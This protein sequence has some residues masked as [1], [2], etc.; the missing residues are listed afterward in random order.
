[1]V[2]FSLSKILKSQ[3]TYC[4]YSE[5]LE[6]QKANFNITMNYMN[7]KPFSFFSFY[8]Y[9]NKDAIHTK[10]YEQSI[11]LRSKDDQLISTFSYTSYSNSTKYLSFRIIPLYDINYMTIKFDCS[12]NIFDLTSE[13]P[14][15]IYN[16]IAGQLYLFYIK[17]NE[18]KK[19]NIALNAN[20]TSNNN[21]FNSFYI[22]EYEQKND[23][24]ASYHNSQLL[25]NKNSIKQNEFSLS[26]SY[27]IYSYIT[28]YIAFSIKPFYNFSYIISKYNISCG[29]YELQNGTNKIENLKS[30]KDYY[31]FIYAKQF[32]TVNIKIFINNM[33]KKPFSYVG[34]KE[35]HKSYDKS[36]IYDSIYKTKSIS[37]F[38]KNNQL[39]TSFSTILN[40]SVSSDYLGVKINPYYDI[41]NMIVEY[42][43][44]DSLIIIDNN[45]KQLY[46]LK[47]GIIY[48]FKFKAYK[49]EEA[50]LTLKMNY[51]ND[52]PFSKINIYEVSGFFPSYDMKKTTNSNLTFIKENNEL[53][54]SIK[55]E[56]EATDD[57]S[58][59][60][61]TIW[62][63]LQMCCLIV[64][65]TNKQET[66]T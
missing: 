43:I 48:Y 22:Y 2:F 9:E 52:D 41:E 32:Q 37:M 35:F 66:I 10:F 50:N 7:P 4:F 11:N 29:S 3:E 36:S 58:V 61:Y 8:E 34:I 13:Y 17:T 38:P 6:R 65:G 28:N 60:I 25:K 59:D 30:K 54:L 23:S 16:L 40:E 63:T 14:E 46:N 1:M 24:Y 42:N 15:T 53:H 12:I 20:T 55:Y 31:L 49:N 19:V 39:I 27:Y 44:I 47:S 33:S 21:P 51:M 64:N 5:V 56:S 26:F 18:F 45:E 57:Y 62:Q